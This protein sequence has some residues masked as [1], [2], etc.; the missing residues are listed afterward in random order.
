MVRVQ[1]MTDK[2]AIA[3]S[4]LCVIHC[5][6]QPLLFF[7]LPA[8]PGLY[9]LEHHVFHKAILFFVVPTGIIALVT[10]YLH[11][12]NRH[13]LV[14]GLL[15]LVFLLAISIWGHDIL[16]EQQEMLLTGLASFIII[17]AH[18]KNFQLRP[19]PPNQQCSLSI[20]EDS[21]NNR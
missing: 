3:F 12:K 11:H 15:G 10:G 17:Y 1:K 14:V 18:V 4:F 21:P 19:K 13:I 16:N 6:A 2:A 8:L 9:F 20:E 7:I 5:V